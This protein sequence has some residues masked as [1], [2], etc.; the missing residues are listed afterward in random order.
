MR[1]NQVDVGLDRENPVPVTITG[2]AED[3]R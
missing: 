3:H 2:A 1:L